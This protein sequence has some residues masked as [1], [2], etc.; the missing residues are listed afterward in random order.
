[1][2]GRHGSGCGGAEASDLDG[3][4]QREDSAVSG[5]EQGDHPL[6]GGETVTVRV[7]REIGVDFRC[8]DGPPIHRIEQTRGLYVE[9]APDEMRTED[10]RR[11]CLPAGVK[12]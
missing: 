9:A 2:L 8:E 6:D 5:V 7:A 11:D 3:V 12:E 10:P 1:M 4:Q